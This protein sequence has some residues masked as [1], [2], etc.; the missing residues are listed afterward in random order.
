M[1]IDPFRHYSHPC[2]LVSTY[3]KYI[4]IQSLLKCAVMDYFDQLD[5]F[6]RA[7]DFIC[8]E[9][10]QECITYCSTG[11]IGMGQWKY[12]MN[13]LWAWL[14]YYEVTDGKW[15]KYYNWNYS[16]R[17]S[18]SKCYLHGTVSKISD[19]V[20]FGLVQVKKYTILTMKA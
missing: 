3:F 11:C 14:I 16:I 6:H 12:S 5:S 20:L 17:K 7:A 9:P 13:I 19:E 2:D 10:F 4:P 1:P 8:V 15:W 18:I